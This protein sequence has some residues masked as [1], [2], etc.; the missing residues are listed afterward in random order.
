VTSAGD[1]IAAV[2][3]APGPGGIAVV[4]VS[5]PDAVRIVAETLGKHEQDLGDRQV[6]VGAARDP[7][8][9]RLDTVLAFVLRGPRSFTGE[10]VAELHGHGG[11][12]NSARLLRAVLARGARPAA[13]GEFTRRA[14]ERGKLDLTRA[15]ALAAV[16]GAG[17]ER[18]WRVAQDQLAGALGA[19]VAALRAEAVGVLAEI[20]AAIDFPDEGLELPAAAGLAA[21]CA[22]LAAACDELGATFRA[23]RALRDG[24]VAAL[25]G[26]V[27]AGK[28]SLFNALLGHERAIV[29]PS[30]GTTRDYV[31]ARTE[32]AGVAVTLIDTA[33]ARE[34]GDDVERRGMA[35][36]DAR[37]ARADVVL[38]LSEDEAGDAGVDRFGARGVLVRSKADLAATAAAPPGAIGTSAVDGRGLDAV[39]ARVLGAAG[40]DAAADGAGVVVTSERQRDAIVRAGAGLAAAGEGVAGGRPLEAAAIDARDG[41]RALAEVLGDE[42]GED[43]LDALFARF[44]IGK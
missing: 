25:A 18:A 9:R 1:T 42:V 31:E 36:A 34:T 33:G 38:W 26:P 41:A 7:D 3:T 20:E 17:S 15:E 19:R 2:A 16:I 43:V 37:I 22:A 23:G 32:W 39:R 29:S 8:G 12:V 21:R 40:V 24:L 35:L 5:G 4:R 13:P 6:V 10:D 44:C 27:N 11:P 14:F 30:P 28:S